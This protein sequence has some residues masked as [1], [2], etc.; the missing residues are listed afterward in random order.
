MQLLKDSKIFSPFNLYRLVNLFSFPFINDQTFISFSI[1]FST[2]FKK[3]MKLYSSR[4]MSDE[5]Y[6]FFFERVTHFFLVVALIRRSQCA[7]SQMQSA[8]P[9]SSS[10]FIFSGANHFL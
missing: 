10:V 6:N 9:F 4:S 5:K 2:V 8:L 7:P 3:I 1:T